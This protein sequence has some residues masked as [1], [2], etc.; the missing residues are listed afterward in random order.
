MD[1]GGLPI[2]G[3]YDPW[4][5]ALSVASRFVRR[6]VALDLA[7]R[8]R[9]R[10]A[11]R[12]RCGWPA[13]PRPW[14]SASGRCTTSACWRSRCRFRCST[15]V[16]TVLL[17]LLAAVARL[18]RRAVRRQPRADWAWSRRADRQPRDGRRHR[19]DALHRHGRRCAS[20]AMPRDDA[21]DSRVVGRRRVVSRL[22]RALAG[23]SLPAR[24]AAVRAAEARRARR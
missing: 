23:V 16:P 7:G 3:S 18:G 12:E 14:A 13:A 15:T 24:S 4:L 1:H 8:A 10:T 6:Y 22:A 2:V 9:R 19:G 20:R 5:V 17:S 11:G 21:V